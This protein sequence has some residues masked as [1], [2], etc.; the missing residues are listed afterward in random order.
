MGLNAFLPKYPCHWDATV[1]IP[2]S[3]CLRPGSGLSAV[4]VFHLVGDGD[5]AP[6]LPRTPQH[7]SHLES[8]SQFT[9]QVSQT[10]LEKRREKRRMGQITGATGVQ[11][12]NLVS[13]SQFECIL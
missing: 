4:A 12:L 2:E 10:S 5:A 11:P 8:W 9:N 7:Y 3:R 6:L 13:S 1:P